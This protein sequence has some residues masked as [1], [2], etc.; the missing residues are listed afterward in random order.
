MVNKNYFS[1]ESKQTVKTLG[2]APTTEA[3]R[4]CVDVE[5]KNH[6]RTI[7]ANQRRKKTLYHSHECE[8][9]AR[10]KAEREA[11]ER[12]LAEK[13]RTDETAQRTAV[14][15][16]NAVLDEESRAARHKE[17]VRKF[18]MDLPFLTDTQD[19][20]GYEF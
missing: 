5:V 10:R 14:R 15:I 9:E 17:I 1:T 16:L 20:D 12:Y 2:S 4:G 19:D 6:K 13:K 11:H 7:N 8:I 18:G 3:D